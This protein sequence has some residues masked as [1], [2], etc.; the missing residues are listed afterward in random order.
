MECWISTPYHASF[1]STTGTTSLAE[2][3]L[4]CSVLDL[5]G[6]KAT[7]E[8]NVTWAVCREETSTG[9]LYSSIAA[10]TQL[11]DCSLHNRKTR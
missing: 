10:T 8:H 1:P 6:T 5:T 9:Q 7:C 2:T 11:V 3:A 4:S